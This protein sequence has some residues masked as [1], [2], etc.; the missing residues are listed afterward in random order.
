MQFLLQFGLSENQT[1][2]LSFRQI[3]LDFAGLCIFGVLDCGHCSVLYRICHSNGCISRSLA[4]KAQL[5]R[6]KKWTFG[7]P[8]HVCI[9][10]PLVQKSWSSPSRQS[11]AHRHSVSRAKS[12][13]LHQPSEKHCTKPISHA[14]SCNWY[15]SRFLA[16]GDPNKVCV[17]GRGLR[18]SWF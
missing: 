9:W 17:S 2:R 12:A 11:Q 15:Y 4:L 13:L 14:A 10:P 3:F 7:C 18:F 5:Y 16:E 8:I 1:L 6:L